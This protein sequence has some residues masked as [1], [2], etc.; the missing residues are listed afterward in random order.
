[1]II[2]TFR[3]TNLFTSLIYRLWEEQAGSFDY[4]AKEGAFKGKSL[5]EAKGCGGE[6]AAQAKAFGNLVGDWVNNINDAGKLKSLCDAFAAKHKARNIS[7]AQI[8][9]RDGKIFTFFVCLI[10]SAQIQGGSAVAQWM[11]A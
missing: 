10:S 9:V 3:F 1:M 8:Q 11:S 4:F 2:V 7:A 6:L 5:A